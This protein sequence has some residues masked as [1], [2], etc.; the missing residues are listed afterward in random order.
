MKS[1]TRP[2]DVRRWPGVKRDLVG[3][4]ADEG[5]PRWTTEQIEAEF[6]RL[7]KATVRGRVLAGGA[8]IDGRDTRTVRPID[9]QV[10]LLPRTHGSALFTRGERRHWWSR[11]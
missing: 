3:E 5:N 9:V 8:R 6:G 4:L 1:W 7:E 10:G 2:P 11:R